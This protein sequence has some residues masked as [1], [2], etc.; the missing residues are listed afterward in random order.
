MAYS[1][2]LGRW[3]QQDPAGYV[4]GLALYE[5]EQ[6]D[7]IGGLDP[8]GLE[9][10]FEGFNKDPG[11]LPNPIDASSLDA[12]VHA[13]WALHNK[14]YIAGHQWGGTGWLVPPTWDYDKKKERRYET[15]C[16]EY[17]VERTYVAT[18]EIFSRVDQLSFP[19][20]ENLGPEAWLIRDRVGE[21]NML[22]QRHEQ[23][24]VDNYKKW[25]NRTIEAKGTGNTWE[26]AERAAAADF[27]SKRADLE[28]G[29]QKDKDAID[30]NGDREKGIEL[31]NTILML[32][33]AREGF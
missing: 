30:L 8:L 11:H 26:A 22:A 33:Q 24:H 19:H 14:D 16:R 2:T 29:W 23:L 4:D 9:V 6:S 3:M 13:Y 7:S 17:H 10:T 1:P 27:E 25:Y 21:F 32:D 20:P 5:Y 31:L 15:G 28:A 18:G 12:W